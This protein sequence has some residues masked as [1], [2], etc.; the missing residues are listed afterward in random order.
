MLA[1]RDGKNI[2]LA[3]AICSGV[4]GSNYVWF[5]E[6]CSRAGINLERPLF[7]DSSSPIISAATHVALVEITRINSTIHIIRNILHHF[8]RWTV[9]DDGLFTIYMEQSLRR[10]PIRSWRICGL[11]SQNVLITLP[12]LTHRIRPFTHSL[13]GVFLCSDEDRRA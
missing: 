11:F 2:V 5:L 6:A 13:R 8:S 7:C 10:S 3:V 4:T 9:G 1:I 12:I